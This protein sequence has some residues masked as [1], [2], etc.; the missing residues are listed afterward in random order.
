[1]PFVG[2]TAAMLVLE[3][4]FEGNLPPE[5]YAYHPDVQQRRPASAISRQVPRSKTQRGA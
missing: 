3:P 5:Q 2:M 1:M 4:V